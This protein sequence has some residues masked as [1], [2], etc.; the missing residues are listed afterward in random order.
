MS[1]KTNAH[2][3]RAATL[4]SAM[5]VI[6]M[7]DQGTPRRS[8]AVR[9]FDLRPLVPSCETQLADD[10]GWEPFVVVLHPDEIQR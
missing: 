1:M 8:T 4:K 5:N 3:E 10:D 6:A 9:E 7:L 2:E